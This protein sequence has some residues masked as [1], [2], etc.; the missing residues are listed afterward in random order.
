MALL[1]ELECLNGNEVKQGD[2]SSLFRYRLKAQ[3]KTITGTG[4][5]QLI[6]DKANFYEFPVKVVNNEVEFHFDKA[7]EVGMYA[8]EIEVA[9]YVFPSK[10]VEYIFV[11]QNIDAFLT[12]SEILEKNEVIKK[13]VS[14]A[15]VGY[16][17]AFDLTDIVAQIKK[18]LPQPT[19]DIPSIVS[20]VLAQLPTVKGE[21]GETGLTGPQG[22]RGE[23]GEQG[24][25]GPQGLIGPQGERGETGLTGPQGERGEKGDTGPQGLKG[26]RG[27]KGDTGP[28]GP[29]GERGPQGPAG[30]G[31]VGKVELSYSKLNSHLLLNGQ[32]TGILVG[33]ATTKFG[34]EF[35]YLETPVFTGVGRPDKEGNTAK[36]TYLYFKTSSE[37]DKI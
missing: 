22:E 2:T 31:G 15:M 34:S 4:K 26:E 19:I 11:N 5:L 18:Q 35:G 13:A 28:Q 37:W 7:L 23:K 25:R 17:P 3:E 27:E 21:R 9:G 14:E 20:E 29:Q 10:N 33:N 16:K 1:A 12:P 32:D 36:S 24:E 6:K 8:I 30:S